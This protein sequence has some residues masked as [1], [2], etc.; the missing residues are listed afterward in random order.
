MSYDL[1]QSKPLALRVDVHG[2]RWTWE[3]SACPGMVKGEMEEAQE[4]HVLQCC[5][6]SRSQTSHVFLFI[7][8][9]TADK[10]FACSRAATNLCTICCCFLQ[11]LIFPLSYHL[12]QVQ[13]IHHLVLWN[14]LLRCVLRQLFYYL[15]CIKKLHLEYPKRYCKYFASCVITSVA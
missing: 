1:L 13:S 8:T 5:W 10:T 2:P 11:N 6:T 4:R 9:C 7:F 14:A 15:D 12:I 3:T